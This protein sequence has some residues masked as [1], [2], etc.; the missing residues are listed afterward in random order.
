MKRRDL[1]LV[2]CHDAGLQGAPVVLMR[3]LKWLRSHSD[4]KFEL[5]VH[6]GGP[7]LPGM[8]ESVPT[9]V[10]NPWRGSST[11]VARVARTMLTVE[12]QDRLLANRYRRR[13]WMERCGLVWINSIAAWRLFDALSL[14]PVPRVLHVHELDFVVE[15]L[16]PPAERL[17]R[18]ATHFVAASQAVRNMLVDRYGVEDRAVSVVYSSVASRQVDPI[19]RRERHAGRDGMG[20]PPDDLVVAGC[21]V[22]ELRKGVDMLPRV[23]AR[24]S[25]RIPQSR[26]HMLWIGRCDSA[27]RGLLSTDAVRLGVG[28]RLHFLG[29]L[30]DPSEV[31]RLAD[32]FVL[33]SR[34]EAFGLVCLEAAQCGVP[35]V[36]FDRV[37][38]APEFVEQDAGRVVPFLDVDAMAAAVAE[39]LLDPDLRR[40]LGDRARQKVEE[41]FTVEKQGPKLLEILQRAAAGDYG[42]ASSANGAARRR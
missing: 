9:R 21:G 41:R 30:E 24:V 13:A 20:L 29:A 8:A 12:A 42:C 36:C 1:V 25:Q 7:F 10:L 15:R 3:F 35:T 4:L 19:T 26:V 11:L 5:V 38:G 37:G 27:T 2:L 16:G 33:P 39:L 34:E 22:G 6:Q 31:F 28:G 32:V 40:R 18:F 23:L 14:P 17:R